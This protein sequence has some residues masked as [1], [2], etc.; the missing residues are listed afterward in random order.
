MSL[1]QQQ[2]PARLRRGA[3]IGGR[4]GLLHASSAQLSQALHAGPPLPWM[5]CKPALSRPTRLRKGLSSSQPF[6]MYTAS[7]R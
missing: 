3:G 5:P 2:Q 7:L 6:L 1:A 4:K